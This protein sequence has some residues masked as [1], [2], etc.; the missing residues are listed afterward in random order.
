MDI[1][2]LLLTMVGVFFQCFRAWATF[3]VLRWLLLNVNA[4]REQ[5]G[6]KTWA[7]RF[8]FLASLF[9]ALALVI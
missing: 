8:I 2:A 5:N 9:S 3:H 6:M 4:W 7:D 1:L